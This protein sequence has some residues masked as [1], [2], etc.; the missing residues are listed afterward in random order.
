MALPPILTGR[1]DINWRYDEITGQFVIQEILGE[2]HEVVEFPELDGR[3]GFR[4]NERPLDNGTIRIY[5]GYVLEDKTPANL[6][7]RVTSEPIGPQINVT[8]STMKVVVPSTVDL[9][10]RY[11]SAYFGVGGGKTVENDLYIQYVALNSK[12]SRDGSLPMTGNLNFNS[13]KAV[14]LANGTNPS[15]GVNFSQLTSLSN[16]LTTEVNA[17]SNADTTINSKLNPL[18]NL[19]KW[20]KFSLRERD[21][22]NDN[23]SGTLGMESYA[24]QKGILLWYNV[25]TCIGGVGAYGNGDSDF[26]IIDDQGSGQYNFRWTSPGNALMRWIL[27]QWASDYAP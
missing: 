10:T 15:D 22:A 7:S 25:R 16:S 4:L 2:V 27:V 8:P 24:G 14:N 23:A 20:S 12:L 5:K 9:G 11:I 17:R 3:R 19:V 6:Q 18:L 21:Y 13:N 26:Q 1:Q